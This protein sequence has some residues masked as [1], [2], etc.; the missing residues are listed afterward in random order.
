MPDRYLNVIEEMLESAVLEETIPEGLRA[1]MRYSLLSGGKRLRPCLCL[2]CCE[3]LGGDIGR[4]LPLACGIE[5]IHTYS[6]VHD[7]LPCM[8][9]DDVRRGKPSNHKVFGE[10]GAM[11][12]GDALLT[13]AFEWMLAHAPQNDADLRGYMRAVLAI[14]RGAGASGMVAGQRLEL[15]GALENASVTLDEVHRLKTGALIR[16][17]A[18]S[19]GFAASADDAA[20]RALEAFAE[21][22]GAL[23]QIT[24]DILDAEKEKDDGK[25]YV[26]LFGMEQAHTVAHFHARKAC[27]AILSYGENAAYLLAMVENT[28]SRAD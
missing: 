24:D 19:G 15:S 21:H 26:T 14:A 2:A 12:A 9:N 3:M 28:L 17:A 18:L 4:A 5:M 13:H 20:L 27:D 1:S 25:N 6:L 8:D 16:A 7:D 23:F 11:L 22:F 10:A